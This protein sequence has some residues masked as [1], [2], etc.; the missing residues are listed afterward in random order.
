MS[1]YF[2]EDPDMQDMFE[3]LQ[4]TYQNIGISN[5]DPADGEPDVKEICDWA[6]MKARARVLEE[7][8]DYVDIY[9]K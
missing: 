2:F 3:D 8:P 1:Y 4:E 7:F 6:F 9:A 5:W